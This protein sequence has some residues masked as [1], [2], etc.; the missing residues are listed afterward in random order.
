MP[1]K[2]IECSLSIRATGNKVALGVT[3]MFNQWKFKAKDYGFLKEFYKKLFHLLE[4]P[5]V[6]KKE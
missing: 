1:D 4:E 6:V 3:N 2:S 5:I